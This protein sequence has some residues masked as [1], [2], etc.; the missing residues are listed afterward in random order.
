MLC[1]TRDRVPIPK[2]WISTSWRGQCGWQDSGVMILT[3]APVSSKPVINLPF[4]HTLSYGLC[5]FIEVYQNIRL[6]CPLRFL[7]S[8][9]TFNS[10]FRPLLLLTAGMG[11]SNFPE[12]ACSLQ[13][14]EMTGPHLPWGPVWGPPLSFPMATGCPVYLLLTYTHSSNACPFHISYINL[15][16]E[17]SYSCYS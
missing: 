3:S 5:S 16:A 8:F 17:S 1:L 15:K 11:H 2:N 12:E 9:T 4:T 13:W 10:S 14:S 6:L 7:D